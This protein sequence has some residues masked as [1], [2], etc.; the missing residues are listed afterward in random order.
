MSGFFVTFEG[1]EGCG[2]STQAKLLHERLEAEGYAALVTREPGGTPLAEQ[3]REIVLDPATENLDLVAELFLFE[4]ARAQHVAERVRPALADGVIVICDRYTDS[5]T[6]YQ[7]GGRSMNIGLVEELH[8]RATGG[9]EPD[10]TFLL[11]VPLDEGLKRASARNPADRME[12]EA[13]EFHDRVRRTFEMIADRD[14]QR[15]VR[16]DGMQPI[17]AISEEIWGHVTKRMSA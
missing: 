6:A 8:H 15:V 5:T 11:E 9:L 17:E 1:I 2:K 3:I 7:G 13:P 12:Q 16:V 10:V 4:A 14:S